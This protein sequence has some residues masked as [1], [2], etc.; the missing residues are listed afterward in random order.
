MNPN[1]IFFLQLLKLI[2]LII[3]KDLLFMFQINGE[4]VVN[5]THEHTVNLIKYSGDTLAMKV[6]TV[7]PLSPDGLEREIH[8]DGTRTLP[9]KKKGKKGT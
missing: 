9:Y 4:V 3:S 2:N 7:K 5:A 6:I 1:K 8:A